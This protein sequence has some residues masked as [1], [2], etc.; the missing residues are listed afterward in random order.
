MNPF[1]LQVK[2]RSEEGWYYWEDC[3]EY[4]NLNKAKKEMFEYIQ[5]NK[6]HGNCQYFKYRIIKYIQKIEI[7]D[8]SF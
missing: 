5:Q 2:S 4:Q 7:Y 1:I 3:H 6:K 8:K